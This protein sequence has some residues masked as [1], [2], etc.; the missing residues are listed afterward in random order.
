MS[1]NHFWGGSPLKI[2]ATNL[3]APLAPCRAD[4]LFQLHGVQPCNNQHP[5]PDEQQKPTKKFIDIQQTTKH[6]EKTTETYQQANRQAGRQTDGRTDKR[7]DGQT[8]RHK[9]PTQTKPS[10][11]NLE[12]LDTLPRGFSRVPCLLKEAGKLRRHDGPDK[13]GVQFL[14]R[15]TPRVTVP[16]QH[17]EKARSP[18]S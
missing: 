12:G 6:S 7:T 9:Q 15:C 17:F 14:L 1:T 11:P 2:M 18:Q 10:P 8:D 3:T 4:G 16:S 5:R 13:H